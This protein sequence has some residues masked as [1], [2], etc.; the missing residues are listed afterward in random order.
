VGKAGHIGINDEAAVALVCADQRSG[1]T[2][3]ED[4]AQVK[5]E[6]AK[7]RVWP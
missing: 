5:E 6:L 2:S 1:E 4:F 7:R 3:T